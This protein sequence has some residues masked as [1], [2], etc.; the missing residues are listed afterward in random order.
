MRAVV[1][2]PPARTGAIQ[3]ILLVIIGLAAAGLSLSMIMP[4]RTDSSIS[5]FMIWMIASLVMV[6]RL[7]AARSMK[8]APA[9]SLA[10]VWLMLA[11]MVVWG[12]VFFSLRTRLV[13]TAGLLF[14]IQSM[15]ACFHGWQL[16]KKLLLP[17]FVFLVVVPVLPVMHYWL[18]L[19]LRNVSAQVATF[20]LNMMNIDATRTGTE[21]CLGGKGFAVTPACSGIVLL[22]TMLWIAWIVVTRLYE[23]VWKQLTHFILLLPIVILTN[24]LRLVLLVVLFR[25]YGV[26]VLMGPIHLWLGYSVIVFSAV[27]FWVAK[28]MLE[29]PGEIVQDDTQG[30]AEKSGILEGA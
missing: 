27:L 24:S 28:Y 8:A 26:Q 1:I 4:V 14:L 6:R 7:V 29:E 25:E 17:L 18:S 30:P 13:W 2:D 22:E 20:T 3:M 21:I 15:L 11:L 19:P 12:G 5:H 10:W 16:Q 9:R 23:N